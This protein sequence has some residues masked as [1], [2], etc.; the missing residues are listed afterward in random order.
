MNPDTND[1]TG[2][3]QPDPCGCETLHPL[4]RDGTSQ[5]QR[6][7]A[8][9]DPSSVSVDE[10]DLGDLLVFARDYAKLLNYYKSSGEDVEADGDWSVFL[11]HDITV[12][13]AIVSKTDIKTMRDTFRA[14]LKTISASSDVHAPIDTLN[15]FRDLLSWISSWYADS[16]SIT[17]FH[18]ELNL[19]FQ[20]MMLDGYSK[21]IA[22]DTLGGFNVFA[23]FTFPSNPEWQALADAADPYTD[24][25]L[26]TSADPLVNN[27]AAARIMQTVFEK[28]AAALQII[29]NRTPDYLAESIAQYPYHKAHLGLFITFLELFAYAQKHLNE[30]T[31]RHLDFFYQEVLQL[32]PEAAVADKVHVIFELA[33]NASDTFKVSQDTLLKAGKDA[34]KKELLYG[35]DEDIVL[36]KAK[37]AGFRNL[38]IDNF[39]AGSITANGVYASPVANSSDGNG[40]ALDKTIPQWQAFGSSQQGIGTASHTMPDARTGFA[41][42]SPQLFLSEGTRIVTLEIMFDPAHAFSGTAAEISELQNADYY[43]FSF[44]GAKGWLTPDSTQIIYSNTTHSLKFIFTLNAK[45]AAVT[46]YSSAVHAGTFNT[47]NPILKVELLNLQQAD[48]PYWKN[49][50]T[51]LDEVAVVSMDLTVDVKGMQ[52]LTLHNEASKLDPSKPFMPFGSQPVIGSPFYVGSDEVFFKDLSSL[53]LNVLWHGAPSD[54]TD[55]YANYLAYDNNSSTDTHQI[56]VDNDDFM[57]TGSLLHDGT[58]SAEMDFL[59]NNSSSKK[60]RLFDD[61]A[62]DAVQYNFSGISSDRANSSDVF[63]NTPLGS[64][65]GYL[66]LTLGNKDFLHTKYA[67]SLAIQALKTTGGK[68]PLP[69]YT[70]AIK[71]F[72][73]DYIS[74]QTLDSTQDQFYHLQP[75]GEQLFSEFPVDDDSKLYLLPQFRASAYN[76][77]TGETDPLM[78]QTGMLFIA[79]EDLVPQ[80]S[81]SLLI[82]VVED[83]GNRNAEAPAITWSYLQNNEWIDL[84]AQQVISDTSNGFQTSGIVELDIPD[85]ATNDNTILPAGYHWLRAAVTKQDNKDPSALCN[86]LD[87]IA[88]AVQA[89]FR[90]NGNDPQHLATALAAGTIAKLSEPLA[91]VKSV[92]QPYASFGGKVAEEGDDYYRRV[93]E[94]LRHKGRAIT[95][96]DYE[97]LVLENFPSIYKVKCISHTRDVTGEPDCYLELAPGNVCLTVVSNL[98]NQGTQAD[99]LKP[100]TSINTRGEIKTFLQKRASKFAKITVINP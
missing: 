24:T 91:E 96:W 68:I 49:V 61:D 7:L 15:D 81:L 83:S 63:L 72:S 13:V 74:T 28:Y 76:Y 8:A 75:F 23:G 94:R 42:S 33:K 86:V 26:Y 55:Q 65:R 71:T 90:D 82:Q 40:A 50:Y 88:Q 36:N 60:D 100:S 79:V 59:L 3:Q 67:Q 22:I 48:T 32:T 17:L 31:E 16:D 52:N 43:Q 93:S 73:A 66:R 45:L 2:V 14:K 20:S 89:S 30:L 1:T 53:T 84:T 80:K 38:F 77:S 95:I 37:V 11:K 10:R 35:T 56:D 64:T 27:E 62:Q 99:L 87:I 70:P 29:V 54:F 19:Y 46:A 85:T 97:R 21:L 4:E 39:S 92:S 98:R 69:P 58:W 18:K 44:T 51:L 47:S 25:S 9:L 6:L 34:L 57:A 78:K 5:A 41:I 12:L